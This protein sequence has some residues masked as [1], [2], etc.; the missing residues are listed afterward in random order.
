MEVFVADLGAA[1][2]GP[3]SGE[4]YAG[5]LA[6]VFDGGVVV[7]TSGLDLVVEIAE[8]TTSAFAF[9]LDAPFARPLAARDAFEAGM[10][11]ACLTLVALVLGCGA[12]T[13]V[14]SAGIAFVAVDVVYDHALR[15][16]H[17]LAV[18]IHRAAL[19]V[20]AGVVI[21]QTPAV[22][23]EPV[24]IGGVD[25]G[26][27]AVG[28]RDQADVVAVRRDGPGSIVRTGHAGDVVYHAGPLRVVGAPGHGRLARS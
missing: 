5:E 18:H 27:A 12:D 26:V 17:D 13:Q 11:V 6:E 19:L 3:F 4:V 21:C 2:G 25:P 14:G 24:V 9:A 22:L 8:V 28:Q 15:R 7:G 10:A 1:V 23:V 20:P 16:L